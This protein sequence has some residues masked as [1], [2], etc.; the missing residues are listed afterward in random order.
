M[1]TY[2]SILTWETPWTLELGGLYSPWGS[3]KN[4]TQLMKH[5]HVHACVHFSVYI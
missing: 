2:S 4:L 5:T 1:V 3:R